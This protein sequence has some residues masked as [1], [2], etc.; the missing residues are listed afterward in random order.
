MLT[1]LLYTGRRAL[2]HVLAA[3]LLALPSVASAA[4][5]SVP[6]EFGFIG[7]RDLNPQGVP[8]NPQKAIDIRLFSTL[9]I[10]RAEFFQYSNTA[11]FVAAIQG[12]DIP[13]TLRL[14]LESD[15]ELLT[16][17]GLGDT[18]GE[19][20]GTIV[21]PSGPGIAS[22][23]GGTYSINGTLSGLGSG[24]SLVL[25]NN[26]ADN[27]EISQNGS[28]SFPTLLAD[29]D[30]YQV[31][32]LTQPSGQNCQVVNGGPLTV[33][34]ADVNNIFVICKDNSFSVGGSVSGLGS[35]LSLVLQ[36]NG[37]DNLEISQNGSF[38]FPTL[39]ADDDTYQVSV[40][41]QP[42]G[43]NC[44]V[45][46]GGPLTVD[47]ADVS[48]I[49]VTCEDNSFSVGGSVSGL[50]SG[51]SLVLQNNGADNLEISQN[52]SFSFPTLLAD[53]DAY[54]ATILNQP[55]G[56]TCEIFNGGGDGSAIEGAD[57]VSISVVC[58]DEFFSIGGTINGLGSCRSLTLQNNGD[59][60]LE[61]WR[62]GSFEFNALVPRGSEYEV[63]ILHQPVGQ[64]CTI[65]E[66]SNVANND[67]SNVFLI[68]SYLT[69]SHAVGGNLRGLASGESVTLQ[70]N[71]GNDLRLDAN[72]CFFFTETVNHSDF[73]QVTVSVQPITQLCTVYAGEG[74]TNA[75][76]D[77]V[78]VECI[79]RED[80]GTGTS[81]EA[82]AV[83]AYP[84]WIWLLSALMTLIT[85]LSR[86]RLKAS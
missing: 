37:A 83:P 2:Q 71:A 11:E 18:A 61:L 8:Q 59:D 25:Q 23:S 47:G 36:N 66:G 24:L 76:I 29:G 78:V 60:D 75:E 13:G 48:N 57:V 64:S 44:Q 28:F 12:N 82:K 52:G 51:L 56:Q 16:D 17:G 33:D 10:D 84:T 9:E 65:T 15:Q 30:T 81:D 35:G 67:V 40:L 50:G 42:S 41:T 1:G 63:S 43:Q 86:F 80:P 77:D 68:C 58:T 85:G 7:E 31:S 46:N 62:D 55:M 39:L 72:G 70:N 27:L 49:F 21:D 54:H 69:D 19:A 53:G 20:N 74:Q 45:I 79:D 22:L 14:I 26:G 32:V 34:G 73:Y 6:F 38:S 5:V 3:V 4:N